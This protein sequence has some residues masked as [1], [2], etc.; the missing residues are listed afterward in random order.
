MSSDLNNRTPCS[1]KTVLVTGGMGFIGSHTAVAL[2]HAGYHVILAD[3]LSNS[4]AD[5][6]ERIGQI[7]GFK[8][9][10]YQI[11]IAD[12][13]ALNRLFASV[14]IQSVIHCAGLKAVGESV[15][16]PVKYYR[17]NIVTT[18]TL[19][20]A[21]KKN[22]VH[23]IVFSSSATVYGIP[24]ILP[25]PETAPAGACTNPYGR[26][27]YFNEL[28][29][30][31]AAAADDT[32]SVVLLR[33]FNPVGA[34]ESG[35]IGE[36]PNNIPNNLMPYMLKAAGGKIDPLKIFGK[37]YET[38]DGTGVR[39]YIHVMDLAEG[40]LAALE[41]MTPGVKVFN[42][43]TGSGVS[44][45]QMIQAFEETNGVAVPFEIVGRRPGDIAECRADPSKAER[46]LGWKASRDIAAM[47]RDAWRFEQNKSRR[48][49]VGND[50]N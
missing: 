9:D 8:P 21:M 5:T 45:L 31:D 42:L 41:H 13:E 6:G 15:A 2:I 40:H 19:L 17:N 23:K 7:T 34:H 27:K 38:A 12:A 46:E 1:D 25:I 14:S 44:V 39:D 28:L 35:L 43:G 20:E 33:Y 16:E 36:S 47:C 37:D 4:R 29:L 26:T 48:M 22:N 11:D 18:L 50:H 10:F 3:N 49:E 30:T 32:L 24:A